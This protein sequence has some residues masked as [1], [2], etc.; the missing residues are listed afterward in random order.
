MSV[1][2]WISSNIRFLIG[3]AV[4]CVGVVAWYNTMWFFV[5]PGSDF[6][7]L[8]FQALLW[9]WPMCI[10]V[11]LTGLLTL[12]PSRGRT[13][14]WCCFVLLAIATAIHAFVQGYQFDERLLWW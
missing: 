14:G 3:A 10:I 5:S 11:V 8:R 2:E 4:T 13:A 7:G 12:P 1:R 6:T 9:L